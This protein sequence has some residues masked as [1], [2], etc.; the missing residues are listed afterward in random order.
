MK[1]YLR[2]NMVRRIHGH[3]TLCSTIQDIYLRSTD[4]KVKL[5]CRIAMRMAKNMETLLQENKPKSE[6]PKPIVK[7]K[8]VNRK[9]EVKKTFQEK[10]KKK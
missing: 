1:P 9:R 7:E 5:L 3:N 10:Y 8:G 6:E 4:S 2:Q